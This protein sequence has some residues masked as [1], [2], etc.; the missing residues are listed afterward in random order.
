MNES[1]IRLNEGHR[2]VVR[3]PPPMKSQ[4]QLELTFGETLSLISQTVY[5]EQCPSCGTLLNPLASLREVQ[6]KKKDTQLE[7]FPSSV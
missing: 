7:L 6:I 3:M 2:N 5:L 4:T 1:S